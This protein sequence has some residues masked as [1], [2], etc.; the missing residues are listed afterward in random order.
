MS[1]FTDAFFAVLG[2]LIGEM[3]WTHALLIALSGY[4]AVMLVKLHRSGSAF[5]LTDLLLDH[6]TGK[7][8]VDN[9]VLLL[10]AAMSAWVVVDRSNNGKDVE[11]LLLGVLGI[12]VVARETKRAITSR[13]PQPEKPEKPEKP[14]ETQV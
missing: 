12:F 1:Q 8:S 11:T 5:N 3:T 4:A 6:R 13:A 14:E 10:M 2:F 9:F 7:A